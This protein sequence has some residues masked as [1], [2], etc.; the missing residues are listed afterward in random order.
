VRPVPFPLSSVLTVL[1]AYLRIRPHVTEGQLAP[2]PYLEPL[3]DTTVR[4]ADPGQADPSR[5]RL[6]S[7]HSLAAGS[8]A[9]YTFTH[10]FP[11][12]TA[13]AEFF[14]R[15]TLPLVRDLLLDGQNGLLFAYGVT[16][17]GKTYTVQGG[18][19]QGAAGILPRTLDVIFNS[20][21]SMQGEGRVGPRCFIS[22][23]SIETISSIVPPCA[24]TRH[25][26]E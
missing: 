1:Q 15:T 23:I 6:S 22:D 3:S 12:A 10:V 24:T 9:D 4:M 26:A 16:N 11:P 14:T 13:Q 8:H 17:S 19:E 5:A 7:R 21:G 18:A 2:A 25:R 20:I